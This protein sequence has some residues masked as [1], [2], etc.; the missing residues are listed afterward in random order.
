MISDHK[1]SEDTYPTTK[2]IS[3]AYIDF[4]KTKE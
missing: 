4:T 1:L 3:K 2:N